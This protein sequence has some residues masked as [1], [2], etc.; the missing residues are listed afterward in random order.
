[1]QRYTQRFFLSFFCWFLFYVS[2]VLGQ[3]LSIQDTLHTFDRLKTTYIPFSCAGKP[4]VSFA[5]TPKTPY[6]VKSLG[7][8]KY[9]IEFT[10]RVDA[11]TYNIGI[12]GG[13]LTKSCFWSV[14]PSRLANM[15]E[16]SYQQFYY[17]RQLLFKVDIQPEVRLSLS[18]YR[19]FY[20]LGNDSLQEFPYMKLVRGPHIPATA[21]LLRLGVLWVYPATGERVPLLDRTSYISQAAAEFDTQNLRVERVMG[22]SFKKQDSLA[23]DE[24]AVFVRIS[25]LK[26]QTNVPIDAENTTSTSKA[27]FALPENIQPSNDLSI[28]RCRLGWVENEEAVGDYHSIPENKVMLTDIRWNDTSAEY[29]CVVRIIAPKLRKAGVFKIFGELTLSAEITT[30]N[31]KAGVKANNFDSR[32]YVPIIVLVNTSNNPEMLAKS[33]VSEMQGNQK[34]LPRSD[35]YF[36]K[37][38]KGIGASYPVWRI[39]SQAIRDEMQAFLLHSGYNISIK[40]FASDIPLYVMAVAKQSDSSQRNSSENGSA[41]SF[42]VQNNAVQL[43]VMRFGDYMI[44]PRMIAENMP[45]PLQNLISQSIIEGKESYPLQVLSESDQAR[46]RRIIINKLRTLAAP[47]ELKLEMRRWDYYRFNGWAMY[48]LDSRAV[49]RLRETFTPSLPRTAWLDTAEKMCSNSKSIIER[50]R[51][52]RPIPQLLID[53]GES[54]QDCEVVKNYYIQLNSLIQ[55]QRVFLLVDEADSLPRIIGIVPIYQPRNPTILRN[56][57]NTPLASGLLNAEDMRE[58]KT[59]SFEKNERTGTMEPT[60]GSILDTDDETFYEYCLNTYNKGLLQDRTPDIMP[61]PALRWKK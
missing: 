26:A 48:E 24:E 35:N 6:T 46:E 1:M 13:K 7:K 60:R 18:E 37:G 5:P 58:F 21:K 44:T 50:I 25:G 53:E 20:K 31:R 9:R 2:Q 17:G 59:K 39:T 42:Y 40:P 57:L 33:G 30:L 4:L 19:V 47:Q 56:Y 27:V 28:N 34:G 51:D 23:S 3:E 45:M 61:F 49:T 52:G 16:V 36:C 12:S 38:C 15:N 55:I 22:Q 54:P 10:E 14:F 43:Q 41:P 11:G 29:S 8:K 32:I